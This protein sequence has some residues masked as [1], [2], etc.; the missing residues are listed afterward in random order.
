[1]AQVSNHSG[2]KRA[3]KHFICTKLVLGPHSVENN[4]ID[5]NI[6]L[7]TKNYVGIKGTRLA[8]KLQ[9][10]E[11]SQIHFTKTSSNQNLD[12]ITLSDILATLKLMSFATDFHKTRD[13]R[14]KMSNLWHNIMLNIMKNDG[15]REIG[16]AHWGLE[17]STEFQ[18]GMGKGSKGF[19]AQ[20]P[21]VLWGNTKETQ[22][23]EQS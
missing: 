23:K 22:L 6:I 16:S 15:P 17:G 18:T 3:E 13:F 1:M 9:T 2:E 8:L 7:K 5:V 11:H 10:S 14:C 21:G 12:V 4:C 20:K 19:Q